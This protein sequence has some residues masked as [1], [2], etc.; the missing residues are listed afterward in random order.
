M[1]TAVGATVA[2]CSPTQSHLLQ[3]LV[4]HVLSVDDD[5]FES[6][7]PFTGSPQI[8]VGS[9]NAAY[10]I[11]TSGTTGQPKLTMLEHGNYCTGA[12]THAEG[13]GMG[14]VPL[15]VL[16]FAAHS[17]DASI[18][19]ILSALMLGGTTCIPNE[20][21][22]LNNVAK[23]MNEMKVTWA[24]LTPTFVRF[25]EPSMVP[26]LKTI[27]LMGEAMSQSNLETWSKINLV[28]G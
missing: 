26:T 19:E 14:I 23:V 4:E 8:Q 12:A 9:H 22:R 3:G 20:E 2:L 7:P 1:A 10:I 15:R 11:P 13:L 25:L 16:Q 24:S 5:L 17:F 6:L 27:I 21:D 18:L 28:N